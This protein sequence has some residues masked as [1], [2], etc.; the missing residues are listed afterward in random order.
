[1]TGPRQFVPPAEP[2]AANTPAAQFPPERPPSESSNDGIGHSEGDISVSR[3]LADFIA[4]RLRLN[5]HSFDT[6][7]QAEALMIDQYPTSYGGWGK[8][9]YWIWEESE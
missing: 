4:K 7:A 9:T 6:A 3:F 5:N 8:S 1:M 2:K